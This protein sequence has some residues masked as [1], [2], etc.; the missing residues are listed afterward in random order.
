[1]NADSWT[2]LLVKCMADR[3][4]FSVNAISIRNDLIKHCEENDHAMFHCTMYWDKNKQG[5]DY[6][7]G[8]EAQRVLNRSFFEMRTE[9]F[10]SP[11]EPGCG[12]DLRLFQ[13]IYETEDEVPLKMS[14]RSI[15]DW[16][17][18]YWAT[19]ADMRRKIEG[20]IWWK[21]MV[22][23]N[24][25]VDDSKIKAKVKIQALRKFHEEVKNVLVD[26]RGQILGFDYT[27][28]VCKELKGMYDPAYYAW[29]MMCSYFRRG[30]FAKE[31]VQPPIKDRRVKLCT[32]GIEKMLKE[33][34]AEHLEEERSGTG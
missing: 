7:V 25:P 5:E 4:E 30:L 22:E 11:G 34:Y 29:N 23:E 6:T 16:A 13:H 24:V 19:G 31:G 14:L 20:K 8:M 21:P 15:L 17:L 10:L 12:L 26:V 1:M 27:H 28:L 18:G 9:G 32:I 2:G 33:A 3:K